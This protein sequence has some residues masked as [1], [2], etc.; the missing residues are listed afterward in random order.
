MAVKTTKAPLCPKCKKRRMTKNGFQNI[1]YAGGRIKR[2]QSWI[3]RTGTAGQ[4]LFCYETIDP[5]APYRDQNGR[6]KRQID[7]KPRKKYRRKIDTS[8]WMVFTGAQ[9]A[10]PVHKGFFAALQSFCKD[11]NAELC[12]IPMRYKNPTSVFSGSQRNREYWLRDVAIEEL[13]TKGVTEQQY[14]Q[15]YYHRYDPELPTW[16]QHLDNYVAKYLYE[17]RRKLND[18]LVV[19]GD[20]KVQPTRDD[21]LSTFTGMTHSESG[22]FGHTSLRLQC[23]PTPQNRLPKIITTTGACTIANYTDS[24]AGKTGEFHHVLGAVVV[25]LEGPKKFHMYHINA[26]SDGSFIL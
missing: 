25:E 11:Q 12:V 22:I 15:K 2:V 5:T 8:K 19:V 20:V 10:T 24:A 18:N 1:T 3:C 13:A 26:R 16:E 17:Q 21:P 23:V 6:P 7:A 9:N 14:H 4:R